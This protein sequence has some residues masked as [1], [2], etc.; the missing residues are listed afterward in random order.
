MICLRT[1][2]YSIEGR[3]LLLLVSV[4][5][6]EILCKEPHTK[7]PRMDIRNAMTIHDSNISTEHAFLEF[8]PS[9]RRL[10]SNRGQIVH[11]TLPLSEAAYLLLLE[12]VILSSFISLQVPKWTAILKNSSESSIVVPCPTS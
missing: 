7:V 6:T 1:L 3:R 12:S 10:L 5:S 4:A 9:C 2:K 8:Q 11:A